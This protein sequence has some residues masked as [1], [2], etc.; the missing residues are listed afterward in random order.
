MVLTV[1]TLLLPPFLIPATYFP[2]KKSL[3]MN[4]LKP[5]P[6]FTHKNGL[7]PPSIPPLPKA[8]KTKKNP[9]YKCG[10]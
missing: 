1:T 3:L 2:T 4:H 5:I 10:S 9:G 7:H 8:K 6:F